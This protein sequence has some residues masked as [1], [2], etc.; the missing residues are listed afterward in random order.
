MWV[1]DMD[2]NFSLFEESEA[3]KTTGT[4]KLDVVKLSYD[5]AES[6]TWK[7]LFS[8]FDHLCA[9]T[10]SSGIGFV[11]QVL[12]LFDTAQIVFGCEETMSYSLQ[13]IMA[14]Q[15]KVIERIREKESKNRAAIRR[16]GIIRR[17]RCENAAFSRKDIFIEQQRWKK[18]RHHGFGQYVLSGFWRNAAREHMLSR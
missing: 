7:E 15:N 4:K 12:E 1:K 18:A 2:N 13:E 11:Y 5:Q 17:R 9:I 8:G 14:F 3:S 16:S 6:L 10:F